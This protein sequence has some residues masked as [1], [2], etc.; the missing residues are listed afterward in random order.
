[1]VQHR[2][3]EKNGERKPKELCCAGLPSEGSNF[4]AGS[5]HIWHT[6]TVSR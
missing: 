4:S 2:I 1:M 5:Q 6:T 3:E